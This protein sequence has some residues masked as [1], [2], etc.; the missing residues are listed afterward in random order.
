MARQAGVYE[1]LYEKGNIYPPRQMNPR[2]L[3]NPNEPRH[4][5]LFTL[6]AP[7]SLYM[8]PN[9]GITSCILQVILY[10]LTFYD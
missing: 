10:H 8:H 7:L 5:Y 2:A 3:A 6:F 1:A 9:W 4:D